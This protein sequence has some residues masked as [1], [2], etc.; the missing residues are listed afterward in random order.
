MLY[1]VE[2]P[3]PDAGPGGDTEFANTALAYDALPEHTKNRIAGLRVGFRPAFDPS[4][5]EVGHPLVR[6]HPETGRKSLYLGNHATRVVGVPPAEGAAL[7]AKL[8]DYATRR[9]FVY[10]HHWRP[11]DLVVWDNRCLLHRLVLGDALRRHKRIMY[12]SV[13]AGAPF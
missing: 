6:T 2:M 10:A 4:R 9:E 1:A 3:P 12:R 8:L 13:V 5:A 7:L 11:G